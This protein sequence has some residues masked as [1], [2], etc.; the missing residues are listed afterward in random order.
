MKKF[1]ILLALVFLAPI[2]LGYAQDTE[3]DCLA[4]NVYYEARGEN[5]KG[6]L[7]VALV[8][9]NRTEDARFPKTICSVV[10]QKRQFSWTSKFYKTQV[11]KKEWQESKNA[12][13]D[14]YMNRNILGKFKA[15]H[16][17][18]FTVS[19]KWGLKKV[20]VI[21]NHIFYM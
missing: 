9:L 2:N 8:T 4:R 12:A 15:T 19:P 14:A 5:Y 17:H 10:Y 20:T 3:F 16:Y 11:N 18:N 7:A 21:H 13:F 6:K 1:L